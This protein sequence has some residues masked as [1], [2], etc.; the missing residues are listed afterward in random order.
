M[1]Q[2]QLLIVNYQLL[3]R[4][5]IEYEFVVVVVIVVTVRVSTCTASSDARWALGEE[6]RRRARRSAERQRH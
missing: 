6:E 2:N 1:E 5:A 3:I 4:P